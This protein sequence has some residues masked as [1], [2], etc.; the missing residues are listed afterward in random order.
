MSGVCDALPG[1]DPTSMLFSFAK[2]RGVMDKLKLIS[3]GQGQGPRAKQVLH[4]FGNFGLLFM[5]R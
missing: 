2:Q 4:G 1:A 5:S 3:L